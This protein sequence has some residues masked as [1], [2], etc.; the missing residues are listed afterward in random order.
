LAAFAAESITPILS[1]PVAIAAGTKLSDRIRIWG[2]LEAAG[3]GGASSYSF[4]IIAANPEG[5]R[6]SARLIPTYLGIVSATNFKQRTRARYYPADRLH[7]AVADSTHR[8]DNDLGFFVK[9]GDGA[10]D[11]KPIAHLYKRQVYQLAEW[12]EVPE[13]IRLRPPTTD[14]YSLAQSQEEFYF[15]SPLTSMDVCLWGKDLGISAAQVASTTGLSPKDVE[16]IYANIHARRRTATY[17]HQAPL[18]VTP[19]LQF[20]DRDDRTV[21]AGSQKRI[22]REPTH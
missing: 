19:V 7:Y 6:H 2:R 3:V 14:T 5:E 13:E 18:L 9:C 22:P 20:S 12:L 8:L 1:L 21:R 10:A 17:L 15:S 11:L 4:F 16:R